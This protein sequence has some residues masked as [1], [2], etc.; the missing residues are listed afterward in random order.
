M[1]N[2]LAA[3]RATDADFQALLAR[4]YA[5]NG[6]P[7]LARNAAARARAAYESRMEADANDS[8][9]AR[10][11]AELLLEVG[12]RDWI[13]LKPIELK[14]AESTLLVSEADGTVRASGLRIVTV[15]TDPETFTLVARPDLS[16]I[17]AIQLALPHDVSPNSVVKTGPGS[18]PFGNFFLGEIQLLVDRGGKD[19]SPIPVTLQRAVST[20]SQPGF[21]I[22]AAIDGDVYSGWGIDPQEG[23]SHSAIFELATPLELDEGSTLRIVLHFPLSGRRTLGRFRVLVTGETTAFAHEELRFHVT[24]PW[25]RLA[26][27]Y[28]AVGDEPRSVAAF[29][30]ALELATSDHAR[31]EVARVAAAIPG[32]FAQLQEQ[33]GDSAALR[34]GSARFQAERHIAG[35]EFQEAVDVASTA[36][37]LFPDDL[38][39]LAIRAAAH[40][41]R[42][43]WLAALDDYTLVIASETDT[44]RRRTAEEG[45]AECLVRQGKST[46]AAEVFLQM[47]FHPLSAESPAPT[48]PILR[49][50]I[51]AHLLAETPAIARAYTRQLIEA[52]DK[53][54]DPAWA[55]ILVRHVVA[56]PGMVTA[57]NLAR[58][59]KVAQTAGPDKAPLLSAAIQYRAGN[60]KEAAALSS[61]ATDE[62][63]FLA[64]A[65]LLH[66][67]LGEV[68]RSREFLKQ[69]TEWFE[70]ERA[71]E[72][73]SV[74]PGTHN[75]RDWALR[76]AVLKEPR[77]K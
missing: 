60:L 35:N 31:V 11:L 63:L 32:V 70:R 26:A 3:A 48:P 16:R 75:W 53:N 36:L 34:T 45:R 56:I 20:F 1:L 27:A 72:P 12:L 43:Q 6:E 58:L 37:E 41:G 17:T 4:H 77:T 28:H 5:S 39:L 7:E 54:T 51:A 42:H 19:S 59:L 66:H 14:S 55:D 50:T 24:E 18:S 76:L 69:A 47:M 65:A 62:P 68:E 49:N 57:E 52:L 73:G 64:L 9:L 13:A 30:R 8:E 22:A 2:H 46:E 61:T 40:R 71:G 15:A 44:V 25:T 74:I 21:P 38:D 33:L 67:D 23:R 10:S 29:R